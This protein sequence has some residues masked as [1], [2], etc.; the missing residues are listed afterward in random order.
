MTHSLK[1]SKL[2]SEGFFQPILALTLCS[3]IDGMAIII[4]IFYLCYTEMLSNFFVSGSIFNLPPY[5]ERNITLNSFVVCRMGGIEPWPPAQ[6]ASML[7][8]TPLP[9]C[10]VLFPVKAVT[11]AISFIE[12]KLF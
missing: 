2:C 6:Q 7:T 8:I 11:I 12:K 3:P 1:K 10:N 9:L 5:A 4:I